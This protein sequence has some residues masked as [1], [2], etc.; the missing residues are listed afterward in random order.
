MERSASYGI[1]VSIIVIRYCFVSSPSNSI[2]YW[3]VS[4]NNEAH[5][6]K[7][8]RLIVEDDDYTFLVLT[9]ARLVESKT[10]TVQILILSAKEWNLLCVKP[11]GLI[12]ILQLSTRYR[13][14]FNVLSSIVVTR[15][16]V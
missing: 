8:K 9:A 10:E 16:D 12:L 6:D 13:P 7:M 15:E 11:V 3:R 1:Q 2:S 4:P 14:K 5:H